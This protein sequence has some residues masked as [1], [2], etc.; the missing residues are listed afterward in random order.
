VLVAADGHVVASAPSAPA[1][2][3][4]VRGVRRVP[5][6]GTLLSPPDAAGIVTRLPRE[7]AQVAVAVDVSGSGLTLDV[8]G[9]GEIRLGDERDLALKAASAQA[10]LAHLD[11][12]PFSYI[13][14]STPDRPISHP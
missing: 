6:P 13:D 14:V 3:V 10:V 12:K 8:A 5:D 2:L 4:E 11:G 1:G 9:G 7:L